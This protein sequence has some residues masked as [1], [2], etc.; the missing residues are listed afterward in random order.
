MQ[1]HRPALAESANRAVTRALDYL[2]ATVDADGAW[3]SIKCGDR[4]LD[5]PRER[6]AVP[7]VAALGALALAGCPDSRAAT[8]HER[9][10]ERDEMVV[11][12]AH[13]GPELFERVRDRGSRAG[14]GGGDGGEDGD[15]E[16]EPE[17]GSMHHVAVAP[18][19]RFG[20][21]A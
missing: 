9:V 17:G 4:N 11:E 2:V 19:Q 3:P 8:L 7:F 12:D 6:E 10:R 1:A 14:L 15:G 13:V 5:G 21:I 20:A 18:E 16:A